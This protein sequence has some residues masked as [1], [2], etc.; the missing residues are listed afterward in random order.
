KAVTDFL[1]EFLRDPYVVDY[2]AWL[3]KPILEKI[4]LRTRPKK[5]ARNYAKIWK[6]SGSP[7]LYITRSIALKLGQLNP[8]WQ[9]SIGM[10]Y[11]NPSIKNGLQKLTEKGVA[12]LVILPLFPQYSSTTNLTAIRHTEKQIGSGSGFQNVT[13]IEDYHNHPAYISALAGSIQD[14]WTLT[15]KPEK[16]LFSFHGVPQRYV[17]KKGEPYQTQCHDTSSLVSQKAGLKAGETAVSFQSRFGPEPWLSPY[18]DKTLTTLGVEGCKS[19]HVLCPGFATD[20][21]ETLEEIVIQGKETFTKAGGGE[22]HYIP[23]LNDS[24]RHIRALADIIKEALAKPN[25]KG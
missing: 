2:P 17:T 9:I 22:F 1:S 4:I 14:A 8:D 13:I 5:S 18:T 16:T 19:I 24:D 10:R 25:E 15:G 20:C 7:L 6:E 23:A 12:Q 21:L 11:G 3:W